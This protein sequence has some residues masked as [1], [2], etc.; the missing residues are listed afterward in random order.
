MKMPPNQNALESTAAKPAHI[1]PSDFSAFIEVALLN[2]RR[3]RALDYEPEQR[4]MF[5]AAIIG[6]MDC[7]PII[8]RWETIGERHLAGTRMRA[9]V[10]FIPVDVRKGLLGSAK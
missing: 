10:F 3:V 6:L 7:L 8:Q 9:R 1:T 4:P 5:W 2:G